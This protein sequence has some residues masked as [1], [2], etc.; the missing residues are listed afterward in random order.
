VGTGPEPA[1]AVGQL[2][3]F[4]GSPRFAQHLVLNVPDMEEALTFYTRGLNMR[5][6]IS[7]GDRACTWPAWLASRLGAEMCHPWGGGKKPPV[8]DAW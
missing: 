7:R 6:S 2:P 3:E 4:S 1:V 8:D 5:V